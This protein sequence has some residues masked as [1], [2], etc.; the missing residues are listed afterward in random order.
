[1]PMSVA[2]GGGGVSP[3]TMLSMPSRIL[4]IGLPLGEFADHDIAAVIV[5]DRAPMV[6][7]SQAL[8]PSPPSLFIHASIRD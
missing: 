1:M 6:Y 3:R 8:R 4:A 7:A 2:A 5:L